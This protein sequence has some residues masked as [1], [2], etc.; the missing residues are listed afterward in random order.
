MPP[1]LLRNDT[2]NTLDLYYRRRWQSLLA[3]DELVR[4]V[5]SELEKN[6]LLNETIIIFTSDNGYHIGQFGQPF[7]KRQPYETDIRVP[8][9]VRGP[10]IP[11]KAVISRPIAL[12]DI[13]PTVFDWA[14]I[15]GSN[16]FSD[17][18]SFAQLIDSRYM[19]NEVN[20][21]GRN[22]DFERKILIEYWG[23]GNEN[24]YSPECPWRR[25]DKLA[26]C[27]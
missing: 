5:V 16:G 1:K 14:G 4:D 6:N 20:Y 9:I 15:I 24:T 23:E 3:V 7:D 26:V 19:H 13:L 21:I 22:E 12:I 10:H 27:V 17:G 11:Q 18:I 8:L 25:K 2:L